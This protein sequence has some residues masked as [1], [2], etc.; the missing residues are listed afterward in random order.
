MPDDVTAERVRIVA[1]AAR[2]PLEA[3]S[4]VRVAAAVTPAV[5]RFAAA[6]LSYPFE[7]EPASFVAVAR[8]DA[9]K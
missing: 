2:V 4:T 5:Q 3:T 6:N 7:T 9:A 1:A 8:G